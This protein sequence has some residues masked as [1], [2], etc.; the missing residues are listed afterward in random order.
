MASILVLYFI[1]FSTL[2]S[3]LNGKFSEQFP[4]AIS[5]KRME[6]MTRLNFYFHDVLSGSSPTAI[7][8]AGPSSKM[9]NKFGSTFMIDDP[10][11]EGPEPTSKL[12]GRAQGMY[13]LA[14]QHDIGLLMV[15]D[16]AF[17]EGMYNGST[18]SILGRNP[19]LNTVR[20]MPIVGGS[21]LFRYARGYA[22]AR[23]VSADQKTGNAVVEYN[24][25][26]VH[27]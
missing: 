17:V 7:L 13:S 23:T 1:L 27:F 8:I 6:K 26:V 4:L 16:F 15:M 19:V 14:S 18:L 10:L 3:S 12:V 25:S 22:L 11:T 20:E 2:F 9:A 24:I 21:G 5:T